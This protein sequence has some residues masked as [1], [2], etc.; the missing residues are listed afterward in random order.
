MT[1]PNFEKSFWETILEFKHIFAIFFAI[2]IGLVLVFNFVSFGYRSNY[3]FESDWV[4]DYN[5]RI[6]K[7]NAEVKLI[8]FYDLQC[9]AC[10]SNDPD[11]KKIV[12]KYSD[13]IEI[14]YR[15]MPLDALHPFA[16]PAAQ[17]AQAVAKQNKSLYFEFKDQ[18]F[19]NQES[20]NISTIESTAKRL[21]GLDY[22][23]WLKDYQ[24]NNIKE[25]VQ[26]DAKDIKETTLP[27]STIT[28]DNDNK[29][30]I[31]SSGTPTNLLVKNGKVLDWWSGGLSAERQGENID[32]ALLPQ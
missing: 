29:G 1:S 28:K 2:I 26:F 14:V 3:T 16:I 15:N 22:D 17:G 4:R 30:L 11:L 25:E 8:Y 20:L 27:P 21:V 5:V 13:R 31:K 7:E 9:P 23:M 19:A 32:R 18:I 12:E 10:K 24:S 6:G